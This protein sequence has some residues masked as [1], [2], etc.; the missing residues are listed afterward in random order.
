MSESTEVT[1]LRRLFKAR[2][3]E[4]RK[5][6]GSRMQAGLPDTVLWAPPGEPLF[7]ACAHL[8]AKLVESDSDVTPAYLASLLAG[9]PKARGPSAAQRLGRGN[10]CQYAQA[11][12]LARQGAAYILAGCGK[13]G[14]WHCVDM[15]RYFGESLNLPSLSREDVV[16]FVSEALTWRALEC[17]KALGWRPGA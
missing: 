8:E 10:R 6:H 5:L 16:D 15:G 11:M 7:G 17:A 2:G 13:N 3:W 9:A 4:T 1:A 14:D 12:A